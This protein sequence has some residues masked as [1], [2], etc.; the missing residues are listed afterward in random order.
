MYYVE[1]GYPEKRIKQQIKTLKFKRTNTVYPEDPKFITSYLLGI[2]INKIL[3][4]A[5][6]VLESSSDTRNHLSTR[7]KIIFN[8]P[9]NKKKTSQPIDGQF[10]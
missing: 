4:V 5:H 2:K 7:P 6:S 1:W 10:K 3:K 9:Q 8:K